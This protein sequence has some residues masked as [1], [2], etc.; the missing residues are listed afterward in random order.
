MKRNKVILQQN[1]K[2]ADKHVIPD[3]NFFHESS[4]QW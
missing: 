1:E 4:D 2:I 3:Q